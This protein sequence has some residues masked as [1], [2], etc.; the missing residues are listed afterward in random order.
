M[1]L[2]CEWFDS[3]GFVS[4]AF[5]FPLLCREI[6]FKISGGCKTELDSPTQRLS[7]SSFPE[8]QPRA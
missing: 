5:P 3:T 8:T 1:Q 6:V 7:D 2:Q 4:N